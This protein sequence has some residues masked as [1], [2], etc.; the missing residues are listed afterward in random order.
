MTE[1]IAP[2]DLDALQDGRHLDALLQEV[3]GCRATHFAKIGRGFYAVV[4]E[5]WLEGDPEHVVVKWHKYPGYSA[6]EAAQLKLLARHA[7]LR[8]PEVHGVHCH[9]ADLPYEALVMEHIPGVN[10]SKI[11]FPSDRV[12]ARF[13]DQ[14]L[15]NLLAWHGVEGPEGFGE[16]GGPFYASWLECLSA[17]AGAYRSQIHADTHRD[18]VSPYV[19]EVIDRSFERLPEILALSLIHI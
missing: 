16:I 8:V 5:A 12:K 2:Y 10:A 13:V 18:T 14:V 15:D 4:Y 9:T 11:E 17:R 19:M 7:T 1:I 6:R 3:L